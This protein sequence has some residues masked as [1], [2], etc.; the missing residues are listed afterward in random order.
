MDKLDYEKLNTLSIRDIARQV[1]VVAPTTKSKEQNIKEIML[2]NNG[3]LLPST[4]IRGRKP[5][6]SLNAPIPPVIITKNF[7]KS[8]NEVSLILTNIIKNT[9]NIF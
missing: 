8:S 4:T 1:G 2:I 7:D 5:K 9:L 3:E 6:N